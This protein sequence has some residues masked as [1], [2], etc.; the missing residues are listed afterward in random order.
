MIEAQHYREA[1]YWYRPD[2]PHRPH[3]IIWLD[4]ATKQRVAR[5]FP[6]KAKARNYKRHIDRVLNQSL[7]GSSDLSWNAAV[8]QWSEAKLVLS[9]KHRTAVGRILKLFAKVCPVQYLAEVTPAMLDHYFAALARGDVA[10]CTGT[11]W[12][13]RK[14]RRILHAFF[15]L[16]ARRGI[17]PTNPVHTI[18]LAPAPAITP[19]VPAIEE[20]C[21]LLEV[22][23]QP[24][25]QLEDPQAWHLFILMAATAGLDRDHLLQAT[26]RSRPTHWKEIT[27]EQGTPATDGVALL[28]ATRPK[29]RKAIYK[30]LPPAVSDRLTNRLVELPAGCTHLF[31]WK[32]FQ[33]KQ[34]YRIR[35]AG[36]FNFPFKSLR[37]ACGTQAAEGQAIEAART[38]LGHTSG[39]T[40]RT[41]YLEPRRMAIALAKRVQLPV[42]PPFPEYGSVEERQRRVAGK[43][44]YRPADSG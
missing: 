35:D 20:W 11:I 15:Q 31:P 1:R 2:R 18:E 43:P 36:H 14:H 7:Y 9:P 34:W 3:V 5:S 25:L 37:S 19:V 12:Q 38:A 4:P 22:L 32:R 24:D 6:T 26:L 30:G 42:L 13:R 28:R 23:P 17:I 16:W 40:T 10:N 27:I 8:I 41:H 44:G 29:S 39:Q 21:R 33:R